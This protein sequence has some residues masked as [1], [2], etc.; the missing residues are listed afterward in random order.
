MASSLTI[1]LTKTTSGTI[2]T[3]CTLLENATTGAT[4]GNFN[5]NLTSG[6]TGWVMI[7]SQGTAT[8]QTGAGSEIAPDAL[9]W[10]DDN[11]TLV[12]NHFIGG[13]WTFSLG[14][15]CTQS[16]TFVA[17]FHFRSYIYNSGTYTLI[18]E[19]VATSQTIITASYTVV[20]ASTTAS[21]SAEFPSGSHLYI[22]C[23]MNISTNGTTGNMRMQASS[24]ST[25]G[26][27][28]AQVVTPGYSPGSALM[29]IC[30]GYGG[31]F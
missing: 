14:F 4:L 15:E 9:G 1:Y 2:S 30:D 16:G 22:D 13:T 8:G 23:Q 5:T 20:N 31:V 10:C 19:A 7:Y 12:G 3:A 29:I 11:S 27:V 28:N 26:N 17:D 25:V 18:C 6:T 24:S 21:P